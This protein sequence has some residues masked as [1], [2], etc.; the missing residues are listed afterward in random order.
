MLH[1][2]SVVA[3]FFV[4]SFVPMLFA[5]HVPGNHSDDSV[6]LDAY[7]TIQLA[8]AKDEFDVTQEAAKALISVA[9]KWISE[10]G[11]EHSQLANV[12]LILNG[13]K[14]VADSTEQTLPVNFGVL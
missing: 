9:E 1:R 14:L 7:H 8:L 11:A 6:L 4:M 13:A 5:D 12:K 2:R 3:L 10:A